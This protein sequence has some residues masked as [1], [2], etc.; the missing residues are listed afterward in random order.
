LSEVYFRPPSGR[1]RLE[2]SIRSPEAIIAAVHRAISLW[3]MPLSR[4]AMFRAAI[5]SSAMTPLV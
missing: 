2:K 4:I 3:F 1:R 5:C